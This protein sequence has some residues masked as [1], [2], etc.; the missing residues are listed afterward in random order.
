[1]WRYAWAIL[2]VNNSPAFY[3]GNI[4]WKLQ[5]GYRCGQYYREITVYL[6]TWEIFT[7]NN[8]LAICMGNINWK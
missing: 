6:Y 4:N 5:C 3:M 7:G 1:M 8:S 2:T